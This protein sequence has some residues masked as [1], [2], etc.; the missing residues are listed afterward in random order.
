M[1]RGKL[2]VIYG[3]MFSNKTG[4]LINEIETL[5]NYGKKRI[6]VIKPK[7]DT[8]SGT[9]F[10][11]NSKG[12]QMEAFEVPGNTPSEIFDVIRREELKQGSDFNIIAIDEVQFFTPPLSIFQTVKEL[13]RKGY[14]VIVAGLSLDF[15]GEP[16]GVTLQLI[17]LCDDVRDVINL[18]SRCHEC[19]EQGDLPQRLVDGNPV[20]YNSD[21]LKVG[22]EETYQARCYKCHELPG[23]PDIEHVS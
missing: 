11:K 15:K 2:V 18:H 13:L 20:P 16:F 4:T 21:Q 22:G 6:C 9:G 19:G 7:T 14:D 5:R 23:K 3:N 12:L 1:K 17:G 8:R 10:I